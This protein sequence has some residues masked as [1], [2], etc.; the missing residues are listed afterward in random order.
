[1]REN[2]ILKSLASDKISIGAAVQ[3]ACVDNVELVARNGY[4]Y[5]WID[6][7]HGIIDTTQC[8]QLVRS[9]EGF[10]IT[11]LV[12]FAD[13]NDRGAIQRLLDV[14]VGGVIVQEIETR[15][16]TARFASI[17]KFPPKGER[18]ACP[19]SRAFNVLGGNMMWEEFAESANKNTMFCVLIES[20]KGVENIEEI[21]RVPGVDMIVLGPFDLSHSLGYP[22][23]WDHP[24]VISALTKVASVAK[25]QGIPVMCVP[26]SPTPD[27]LKKEVASWINKGCNVVTATIDTLCLNQSLRFTHDMLFQEFNK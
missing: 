22:G 11:S 8:V 4:D 1:M 18:G 10:G 17:M 20:Y 14:G 12:R 21:V 6:C 19:G 7:E 25:Q 9:A 5:V 26:L 24:E 16:E 15:E 23:Q 3:S 13:K 2:K 27:G